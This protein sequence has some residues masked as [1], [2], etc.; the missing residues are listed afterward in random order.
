MR[1]KKVISQISHSTRSGFTM[2]E[3]ALCLAIIGFAL[4][5]IIGI[6]PTGMQVQKENR[7]DTIIN[8]DAGYWMEAI[9]NGQQDL[10]TLLDCVDEVTIN[11]VVPTAAKPF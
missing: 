8:Q 1:L 10:G 3:I 6:L 5:A 2:L 7:E 4:V 11:D 9:R